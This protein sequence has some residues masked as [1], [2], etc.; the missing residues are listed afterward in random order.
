MSSAYHSAL[1]FFVIAEALYPLLL[2]VWIPASSDYLLIQH[3]EFRGLVGE[4]FR[5]LV[6]A[7]DCFQPSVLVGISAFQLNTAI[8]TRPAAMANV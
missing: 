7:P 4:L 5:R 1:H 8:Y 6:S 2:A 3:T